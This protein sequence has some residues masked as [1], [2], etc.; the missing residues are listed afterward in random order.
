LVALTLMA[1]PAAAQECFSGLPTRVTFNDGRVQTIIQRHGADVTYTTPYEGFQDS[2]LKTQMMLF[3]KQGR[4]GARSTEYRW[5]SR[6]PKLRDMVPGYQFDIKGT[7]KSGDGSAIPYRNVGEVLRIEDVNVG[8]CVYS[9]LVI[10]V[11]TYLNDQVEIIAT[12]YLSP[13]LVVILKSEILPVS[14]GQMIKRQVV[15]IQ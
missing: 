1:A 5:T 8:A 15:A 13:D 12:D 14:A 11:E 4:A 10:K 3:P 9:T 7:M 2:V 6:L